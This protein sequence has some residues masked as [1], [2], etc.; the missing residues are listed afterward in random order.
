MIHKRER[1]GDERPDPPHIEQRGGDRSVQIG[2]VG[3]NVILQ[4]LTFKGVLAILAA[5]T[6]ALAVGGVLYS[7]AQKPARMTG[8]FNIAVAQFGE[9]KDQGIVPS[10][11]GRQISQS[12]FN[13]LDSEY[14]STDFGLTIQVAHDKIGIV[15]E[16]RE[17]EKLAAD[18]NAHL[19]IYGTVYESGGEA[20]LSPRFYI[21][22]RK[23]SAA[24]ITG[25]H[26]LAEPIPFDLSSLH[27]QDVVNAELRSRAAIL[28]SFTQG[29]SFYSAGK[30]DQASRSFDLSISEAE[31]S[32]KPV[33]QEAIYLFA[34]V[35]QSKQAD[36][37][38]AIALFNKAISINPDYARAYL[39]LGNAY[40]VQV[41]PGSID[42]NLVAQALDEYQKASEARDQPWGAY[43]ADKA[44]VSLGNVYVLKAQQTNDP[45][46]FALAIQH[47]DQVIQSYRENP[48]D[49]KV[50]ELAAVAYFGLGIAYERQN[51]FEQAVTEYRQCINQAA[52]PDLK[53]RAEGQ[54]KLI[55]ARGE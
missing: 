55:E 9:V 16:A 10:A 54:I 23:F 41:N 37:D 42:E 53:T 12:L 40:Y 25:Q 27:F 48:E 35:I 33:G 15:R 2:Q 22:D 26:E 6:V 20:V 8:D 1:Q 45:K 7:R 46:L 17:A 4:L 28:V 36:F 34:G 19:V 44:N 52:D 29:L 38:R 32:G 14:K 24:E 11:R 39:A 50:R 13:F 31:K 5:L 3:G 49:V 30:L 18:L 47:Y 21:A 51:D 43:I